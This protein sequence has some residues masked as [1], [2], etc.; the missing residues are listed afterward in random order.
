MAEY[1]ATGQVLCIRNRVVA[2]S[3][4]PIKCHVIPEILPSQPV[5]SLSIEPSNHPGLTLN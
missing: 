2:G 3:V 1:S 4:D 5:A